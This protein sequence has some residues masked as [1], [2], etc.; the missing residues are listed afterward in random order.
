MLDTRDSQFSWVIS[1]TQTSLIACLRLS[2]HDGCLY[3][4]LSFINLHRFSIGLRSW[5][6]PGHSSTEILFVFS[7]RT[8]WLPFIGNKE[9]H[10]AVVDVRVQFQL[11]FDQ[12]HVLG[13]IHSG[14][15]RNEIPISSATA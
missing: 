8:R 9:R 14:A 12:F 11:L 6:L 15:R 4:T 10:R 1:V 2:A 7:L 5:L 13:S 3:A